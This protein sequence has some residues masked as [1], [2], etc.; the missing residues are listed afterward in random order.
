MRKRID[1]K[2]LLTDQYKDASNLNARF[3]LH[4]RFSKN[5]HGWHR[6]VFDQFSLP[7]DAVIL[8]LGCGPGHLWLKNIDRIPDGWNITLSDF[9]QGMLQEAQQNL[10]TSQRPFRFQVMD[11]Q[12]I[13]FPDQSF[14]AVIANHM[15][16]HVPDRDKAFSE[17]HRT[18][19]SD[20]CFYAATNGQNHLRQLGELV[21]KFDPD[22]YEGRNKTDSGVRASENF[23]L[24]NG[25]DQLSPWFSEVTLNRYEDSLVITE[26]EPL[27]AW[28]MSWAKPIFA[29][30]RLDDFLS[31]LEQEM[32]LRGA[33]QVSKDPGIFKAFR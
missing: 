9:S 22:A 32:A 17:I 4:E 27:I 26:S 10:N 2:Y 8:E 14:D 13:A 1:A 29:G 11:A 3:Q 19:R 33:I 7:P 24:E 25:L 18:L 28:A 31:F 15:L 30:R 5:K 23:S 12:S 6:W 21:K 20:G 16:Y